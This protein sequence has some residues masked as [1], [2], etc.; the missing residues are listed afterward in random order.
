MYSH[1][2]IPAALEAGILSVQFQK[3]GPIQLKSLFSVLLILHGI[4]L[5]KT[6]VG[7]SAIRIAKNAKNPFFHVFQK[8]DAR[9]SKQSQKSET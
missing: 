1:A 4:P 2:T 6:G 8:F 3:E 7:K 9:F 5:P